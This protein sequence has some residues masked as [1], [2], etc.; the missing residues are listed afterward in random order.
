MKGDSR[1]TVDVSEVGDFSPVQQQQTHG[2]DC[3]KLAFR[4]LRQVRR[5]RGKSRF[6]RKLRRTA[7][8]LSCEEVLTS[9]RNDI[10]EDNLGQAKWVLGVC[11]GDVRLRLPKFGLT[12][13]HNR[14]PRV[15]V[16]V[17]ASVPRTQ[18]GISLIIMR[19]TAEFDLD[20]LRWMRR[21]S[22]PSAGIELL[23]RIPA[24]SDST[25]LEMQ[26]TPICSLSILQRARKSA[27]R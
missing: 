6:I 25:C 19:I 22:V 11:V 27:C 7:S 14:S 20:A 15:R 5:Y 26:G 23:Q 12:R 21:R 1:E 18:S 17:P 24:S 16:E 2:D 4:R 3:R 10:G 13:F 8:R 9:A